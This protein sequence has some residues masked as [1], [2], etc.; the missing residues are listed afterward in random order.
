MIIVNLKGGLGNQMFQYALGRKL[1]LKNRDCFKLDITGYPRQTLR[2][3]GLSAFRIKEDIAS[4]ATVKKFKYPFGLLSMA[5][6]RFS[7]KVLRRFHTGWEPAILEKKGNIYLDGFWQSYKYF[8]DIEDIIRADFKLK[9]PLESKSPALVRL[10]KDSASVSLHIRR[11]D[12]LT[13]SKHLA[14]FGSLPLSYYEQ[15]IDFIKTKVQKPTLF[16]FSDDPAWVKANL[17]TASLET[18]YLAD[19]KLPDYEELAVMSL[20]R[21]HII[22]NSTFSWWGAWLDPRPDKIVIAP[23]HWTKT[24]EPKTNDI[25][26]TLWIKM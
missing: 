5:W 4:N 10:I 7:F 12:Y 15:A 9:E 16:I 2:S 13:S 26:P 8:S 11:T 14:A 22:A 6:R 18:I 17:P 1:A 20:C 25:I 24:G 3:Y 23:A 21:H 19:F